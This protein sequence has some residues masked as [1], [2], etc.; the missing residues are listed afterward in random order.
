[1]DPVVDVLLIDDCDAS[2]RLASAA[3]RRAVPSASVVRV[4]DVEQ[5]RRLMFDY[6]LFTRVPQPPRLLIFA[7]GCREHWIDAVRDKLREGASGLATSVLLLAADGWFVSEAHDRACDCALY[8]DELASA[9][10]QRLIPP[11]RES[12]SDAED[13]SRTSAKSK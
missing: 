10:A 12:G 11:N 5:A 4:K 13:G 9:I 6:G 2:A 3:V 1:M 7:S 8:V